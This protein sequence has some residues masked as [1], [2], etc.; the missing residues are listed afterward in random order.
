MT[1]YVRRQNIKPLEMENLKPEPTSSFLDDIM[2]NSTKD[3]QK[4]QEEQQEAAF[5]DLNAANILHPDDD[6]NTLCRVCR[7]PIDFVSTECVICALVNPQGL[8]MEQKPFCKLKSFLT[9]KFRS[10]PS[11]SKQPSEER[12]F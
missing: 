5:V 9:S 11:K 7:S 6:K 8:S 10:V 3:T 4:S 2:D 12:T 1:Q